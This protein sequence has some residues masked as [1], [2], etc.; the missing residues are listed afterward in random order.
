MQLFVYGKVPQNPQDRD[1]IKLLFEDISH[2]YDE[3]FVWQPFYEAI[4]D[5]LV[6]TTYIKTFKQKQELQS[7]QGI[8]LSLGGDGTMLDTLDYVLGTDI[9]VMGINLGHLGFLTTAGREDISNL[10]KEIQNNNFT[11]EK[12]QILTSEFSFECTGRKFAANE[13]C[14]LSTNRGAIIDLEVF[15]NDKYVTTFSGDG[16]LIATPTGSTAYSM[17]AGGPIIT[18]ESR[19]FCLTPVAPHNLTLRPVIINDQDVIK[20]RIPNT[21]SNCKMLMDGYAVFERNNGEIILRKAPYSWNLVRLQNQDF[22][23]SIRNK[24]MWGQSPRSF[25]HNL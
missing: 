1:L 9:A 23:F 16:L 5:S 4:K 20:V 13:A 17:S 8:L 22:Y 12:R 11:I 15:I 24:L 6:N 7:L 19:C 2:S 18:P 21:E 10:I 14:F 3:V 25:N